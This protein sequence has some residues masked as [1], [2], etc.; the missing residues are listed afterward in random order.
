MAGAR[1]TTKIL[2]ALAGAE[3]SLTTKNIADGTGIDRI[4]VSKSCT[5]LRSRGLIGEET[6]GRFRAMSA[7]REFLAQ[8]QAVQPGPKGPHT[9][10][11]QPQSQGLRARAWAAM[12]AQGQ[13]TVGGLVEIAVKGGEAYPH[14]NIRAYVRKLE[15]A[16]YVARLRRR[17]AGTA[18]TSN[19][20]IRYLLLKNTGPKAPIWRLRTGVLFDPNTRAEINFAPAREPKA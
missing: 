15:A 18:P 3:S 11:P 17:Q 13:F 19:G 12:R 5:I 8:G 7:G 4:Q 2:N 20:Y 1:T 9:G 6:V 14:N 16:G 10:K